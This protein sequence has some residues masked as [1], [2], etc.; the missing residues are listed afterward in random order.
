MAFESQMTV[1]PVLSSTCTEEIEEDVLENQSNED[2]SSFWKKAKGMI[3]RAKVYISGDQLF[4]RLRGPGKFYISTRI[5]SMSGFQSFK[6]N[7]KDKKINNKTIQ[8][9][10]YSTNSR[11]QIP[12]DYEIELENEISTLQKKLMEKTLNKQINKKSNS[13]KGKKRI[14][15]TS[16]KQSND[17]YPNFS[18]Q[19]DQENDVLIEDNEILY[20]PIIDEK[21]VLYKKSDKVK[22][23]KSAMFFTSRESTEET[24]IDRSLIKTPK[25]NSIDVYLDEDVGEALIR[26]NKKYKNNKFSLSSHQNQNLKTIINAEVKENNDRSINS[27]LEKRTAEIKAESKR[28]RQQ[29]LNPKRNFN[30]DEN[31]KEDDDNE[32]DEN[33]YE[34][35]DVID[36]NEEDNENQTNEF[37]ENEDENDIIEDK[38]IENG[39]IENE[40]VEDEEIEDKVIEDENVEDEEIEDEII[41]DENIEDEEVEDEEIEIEDEEIENEII[42]DEN[43]DEEV[44]DEVIENEEMEDEDIEE[45]KERKKEKVKPKKV[46]QTNKRKQNNI[47]KN[48]QVIKIKNEPE[49]KEKK[50]WTMKENIK[51]NKFFTFDDKNPLSMS[52]TTSKANNTTSNDSSFKDSLKKKSTS[53]KVIKKASNLSKQS[54][55]RKNLSS[56]FKNNSKKRP[57]IKSKK[58]NQAKKNMNR[59]IPVI[60]RKSRPS[61][62]TRKPIQKIYDNKINRYNENEDDYVEDNEIYDNEEIED[63]NDRYIEDEEEIVDDGEEIDE[64]DIDNDE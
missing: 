41:E 64:E 11:L 4:Y 18:N 31:K 12:D 55:T 59:A 9:R 20:Q 58:Q 16:K 62:T 14:T 44:E 60:S 1:K 37:D 46:I 47:K 29:E 50:V 35:D 42:E 51:D 57:L 54:N 32:I 2:K 52:S 8:K 21:A 36:D 34:E 15:S 17:R 24:N 26:E 53:K 7:N 38:N 30:V 10:N 40:E 33:E 22:S 61:T 56:K 48:K 45:V 49:Q 43:V 19:K 63:D 13:K 3:D 39:N 23:P 25:K 5:P 6:L 28:K 27:K